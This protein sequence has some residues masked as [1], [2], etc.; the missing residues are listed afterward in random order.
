MRHR[1]PIKYVR[2]IGKGWQKYAYE[3][4]DHLIGEKVGWSYHTVYKHENAA[5]HEEVIVDHRYPK[6]CPVLLAHQ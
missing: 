5:D 1:Q 3:Q 2:D 4:V 6:P